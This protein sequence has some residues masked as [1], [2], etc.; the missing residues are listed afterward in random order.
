MNHR[1]ESFE[2]SIIWIAAAIIFAAGLLLSLAAVNLTI[3]GMPIRAILVALALLM[4]I[5][6][7]PAAAVRVLADNIKLV[8]IILISALI[9]IVVSLFNK[10]DI[11]SSAIQLVEIQLQAIIGLL[12][13]T[14]LVDRFG[15]SSSVK[16]FLSIW[17]IGA[18]FAMGQ[19]AGIDIAWQVRSWI[20][21]WMSDPPITRAFYDQRQRAVGLSFTPVHLATQ[22]C[23]AFAALFAWRYRCSSGKMSENIDWPLLAGLS[24]AAM[25]CIISGN[26]SPL[27]GFAAFLAIYLLIAGGRWRPVLVPLFLIAIMSIPLLQSLGQVLDLRI[28]SSS[29][30]SAIGRSTLWSFGMHLIAER[31]LG[32]GLLFSSTEHAA[33]FSHLAI[34]MD[35]SDIIRHFSLHNYYLL[36]SNKYGL[37]LLFLVP[38]LLPRNRTQLA[39][40]L[41]FVPYLIHI[42]FHNDGPLNSDFLIWFLLPLIFVVFRSPER[43]GKGKKWLHEHSALAPLR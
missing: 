4:L 30:G 24:F 34:H 42:A 14:M 41:G 7:D 10:A 38:W 6:I 19:A 35:N 8:M 13:A 37:L 36:V 5:L 27:L 40:W 18:L 31:P 32:Y 29:D 25:V 3:S 17:L 22:T 16:L 23:L 26:R 2:I 39:G 11:V 43:N 12:T 20:G 33:G 21:D 15:T 9:G 28:A 1:E